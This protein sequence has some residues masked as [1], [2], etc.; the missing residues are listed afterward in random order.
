[1]CPE[2]DINL[3]W[4]Q[5]TDRKYPNDHGNLLMN[6]GSDHLFGNIYILAAIKCG[7]IWFNRR[8]ISIC[9]LTDINR[10]WSK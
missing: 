7:H 8:E 9:L 4:R 6:T 2:T 5:K 1:M 3:I 10:V